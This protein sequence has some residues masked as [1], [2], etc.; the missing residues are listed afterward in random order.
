VPRYAC[1]VCGDPNAYPIWVT[2]EPPEGCPDDMEN[3]GKPTRVRN[4]TECGYQMRK[5]AQRAEWMRLVP[6]AY[7]GHGN[8][9][10]G[11]LARVL[12]AYAKARPDAPIT[13]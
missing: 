11:Q 12:L 7:D 1:P 9:L 8:M 2:D 10:P 5:A 3:W 4:V 6:D 13:I